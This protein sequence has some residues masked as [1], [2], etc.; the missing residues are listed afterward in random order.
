[1][2]YGETVAVYCE[3]HTDT[4][5][6][7]QE[8]HLVSASEPNRLILLGETVGVYCENH[9]KLTDTVRTSQDTCYVSVTEPKWL[10]FFLENSCC[11]LYEPY[12]TH[13]Y[14]PYFRGNTSRFSFR[15]QPINVV[16]GNS[17]C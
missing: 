6:T 7:S 12:A 10:M 3:S 13:R 2:L 1:M 16:W 15:V 4:V 11:L 8:T 14:N 17:R 5:R 9:T